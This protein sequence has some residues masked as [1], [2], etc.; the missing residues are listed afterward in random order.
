MPGLNI[1]YAR[2]STAATE[3]EQLPPIATIPD[4][5]EARRRLG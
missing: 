3:H 2:V 4:V 1:G 5:V